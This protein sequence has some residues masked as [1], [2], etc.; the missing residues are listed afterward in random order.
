MKSFGTMRAVVGL[1]GFALA[2]SVLLVNPVQAGPDSRDL[3]DQLCQ[4]KEFDLSKISEVKSLVE[5]AKT[6]SALSVGCDAE[7]KEAI[8]DLEEPLQITDVDNHCTP[9]LVNSI[10]GYIGKHIKA[11]DP[12]E[13]TPEPVP[14]KHMPKTLKRFF[15]GYSLI[16]SKICKL[17]MVRLL[18]HDSKEFVDKYD[19]REITRWTDGGDVSSNLFMS[20][21][22]NYDDMFLVGNAICD[23]GIQTCN[24]IY[25]QTEHWKQLRGIRATC[26]RVLKPFYGQLIL[27]IVRLANFGIDYHDSEVDD[28][29]DDLR[30]NP[31]LQ[32]WYKI[33]F[34]CESLLNVVP[35]DRPHD[36]KIGSFELDEETL[37]KLDEEELEEAAEE[38]GEEEHD[39]T[40]PAEEIVAE[41]EE[42]CDP[43]DS[44]EEKQLSCD[45]ASSCEKLSKDE[46]IKCADGKK[47]IV[48]HKKKDKKGNF[49]S[50][51]GKDIIKEMRKL[52][53]DRK[54]YLLSRKKMPVTTVML[55]TEVERYEQEHGPINTEDFGDK[56]PIDYKPKPKIHVSDDVIP[57]NDKRIARAIKLY[58]V[59]KRNFMQALKKKTKRF[60]RL[61]RKFSLIGRVKFGGKSKEQKLDTDELMFKVFDKAMWEQDNDA[62]VHSTYG[63]WR[64]RFE[65][66]NLSNVATCVSMALGIVF[67]IL[68]YVGPLAG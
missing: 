30:E 12:T 66:Q 9:E 58:D 27:P 8:L 53:K 14:P 45:K 51:F 24:Q 13:E 7:I 39:E 60:V 54:A 42:P 22:I 57:P 17:G 3:Y 64:K 41:L 50:R 5:F 1:F 37:K 68:G 29:L 47:V 40:E 43:D 62:L 16:I 25:V 35:L 18:M 31:K 23:S 49:L 38:H 21:A 20:R 55:K 63:K 4:D 6:P 19:L 48:K 67:F 34:L 15:I 44:H 11:Q 59:K 33:V 28:K 2:C 52:Q 36:E 26:H 10:T 65:F 61:F 32:S 56:P 46:Q